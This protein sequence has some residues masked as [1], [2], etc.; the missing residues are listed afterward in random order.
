MHDGHFGPKACRLA[1]KSGSDV[2]LAGKAARKNGI[3]PESMDALPNNRPLTYFWQARRHGKR[4]LDALRSARRNVNREATAD[5]RRYLP[6]C[7]VLP[8]QVSTFSGDLRHVSRTG[9]LRT[10]QVNGWGF[11]LAK[12]ADTKASPPGR[13]VADYH[14]LLQR[15]GALSGA[16]VN[17]QTAD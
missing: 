3:L 1:G 16:P 11:C 13:Q 2:L 14:R 9:T 17:A 6:P 15:T 8:S 7:A 5:L 4:P 10:S 12:V